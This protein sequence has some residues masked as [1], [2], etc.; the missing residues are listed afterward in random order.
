MVSFSG[1]GRCIQ[2]VLMKFFD[3]KIV[4]FVFLCMFSI[5]EMVSSNNEIEGFV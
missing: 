1:C 5:L 4:Q 3:Y 2:S